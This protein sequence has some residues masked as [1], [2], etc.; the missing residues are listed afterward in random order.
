VLGA[1]GASCSAATRTFSR[2]CSAVIGWTA[3]EQRVT[4]ERDTIR[5]VSDPQLPIV[6]TRI[7]LIVCIRF[8][9]WSKTIEARRL[10]DLLRDLHLGDPELRRPSPRRPCVRVVERGQAVHE[11]RVRVVRRRASSRR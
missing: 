3:L 7:A 10:E 11:L 1:T 8:S 9:A 6:A 5:I 4:P 2:C